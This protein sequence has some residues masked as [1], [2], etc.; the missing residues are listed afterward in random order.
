MTH[1]HEGVADRD[2]PAEVVDAEGH[3]DSTPAVGAATARSSSRAEPFDLAQYGDRH[4]LPRKSSGAEL[5]LAGVVGQRGVGSA[6]ISR[7][8]DGA[9]SRPAGAGVGGGASRVTAQEA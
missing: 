6:V 5:A 8:G 9:A 2:G 1:A 3:R 7:S 4:H